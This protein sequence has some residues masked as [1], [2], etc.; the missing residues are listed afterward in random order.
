MFVLVPIASAAITTQPP[1]PGSVP[2]QPNNPGPAA[3]SGPD[4]TLI[5]PLNIG[6][7]AP[8]QNCL[9]NFLMKILDL[10]IQIGSIVIIFMIVYI[11]FLFVKAQ[12]KD[13][14]L[15]KAREALLW[16]VIG[17]LV[18]LGSKAIAMGIQATVTS[19]GG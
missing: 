7:C 9:L 5:N 8:G 15:T 17:G 14:E 13:A 16:T 11:G 6:S 10:V 12:G 2:G 19:L 18:L 4:I 1:N 3:N